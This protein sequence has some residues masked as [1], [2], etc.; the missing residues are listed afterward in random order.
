MV[1]PPSRYGRAKEVQENSVFY[2]I[3]KTLQKNLK[4]FSLT[5]SPTGN[6]DRNRLQKLVISS[7][8]VAANPAPAR[9]GY[10]FATS[11]S[12]RR[13]PCSASHPFDSL[14]DAHYN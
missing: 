13:T 2:V 3:T 5:G 11:F 4:C 6:S 9:I 14:N 7:V 10:S 12:F 1:E 8:L